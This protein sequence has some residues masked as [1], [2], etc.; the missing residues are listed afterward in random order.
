MVVTASNVESEGRELLVNIDNGKMFLFGILT[1]IVILALI[2]YSYILSYEILKP[3]LVEE[4]YKPFI[5]K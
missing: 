2:I 1:V 3:Y 5:I 4:M